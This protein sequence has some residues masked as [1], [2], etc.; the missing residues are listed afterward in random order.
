MKQTVKQKEWKQKE[1]QLNKEYHRLKQQ[2]RRKDIRR[3]IESL[4]TPC[5]VCDEEDKCCIDFHHLGKNKK[6]FTIADATKRKWSNDKIINEV[7]KCVCIC[8]NHHRKLHYYELSVE[9]TIKKY[10]K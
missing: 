1:Y 2:E 9:E 4:K 5:V 10:K 6:D 3:L 7:K 8:S